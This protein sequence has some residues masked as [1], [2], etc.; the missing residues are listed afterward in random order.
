MVVTEAA[1]PIISQARASRASGLPVRAIQHLVASGRLRC[2]QVGG[3]VR[4]VRLSDVKA[5][6]QELGTATPPDRRVS[7]CAQSA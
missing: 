3:T 7:A 5:V 4:R 1:E 6:V 2:Y